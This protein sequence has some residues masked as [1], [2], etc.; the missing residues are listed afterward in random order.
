MERINTKKLSI[1][2]FIE[3]YVILIDTREKN[4]FFVGELQFGH[5]SLTVKTKRTALKTGD[6]SVEGFSELI[7]Y[8]RK[9][10]AD[11]WHSITWERK[12]FE[13]EVDRLTA[14]QHK[15][16][17]IEG[18][19]DSATRARQAGRNISPLAIS[20]T[21]ASWSVKYQTP[22]FFLKDRNIAEL[23]TLQLLY[24]AVKEVKDAC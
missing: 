22:F 9:S 19:L 14:Y 24:N 7:T 16:V 13:K 20:G 23:F 11:F 1:S 5:K 21:V 2:D 17:I 6:Y 18:N 12:R 8:E 15:A 3:N 4:P 10:R